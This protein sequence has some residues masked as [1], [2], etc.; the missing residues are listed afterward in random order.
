M[1]KSPEQPT[2][3]VVICAHNEQDWITHTLSSLLV[4]NRRPDE[5]V[6]VDNA[7]TDQTG[8]VVRQFIAE[9]PD[10]KILLVEE[11]KKGLHIAR[12][13]G[14]RAAHGDLIA[15]TD[16]DITFP[17]DWLQRIAAAFE[18]P[19]VG[20]VTGI[21]RYNDALPIAN[22]ATRWGDD[23]RRKLQTLCGGNNAV[24]RAILEAVDGYRDKPD[25]AFEDQYVSQKILDA[26]YS[27]KFDDDLLVWH[28]FR[29]FKGQGWRGYWR[30]MF[31]YTAE[32]IYSDHLAQ[33]SPYKITVLIP[34][35]NEEKLIE[36]CID[37]VARQDPLPYEIMVVDNASTDRTAEIV[38]RYI[39][40]HPKI[41]VKMIYET[42]KGCPAAREAGWRASGGDVIIHIDAD[43]IVPPG[44]LAR[45]HATLVR[46]PELGAIG[47][48]VRFEN[49]PFHIWL[50]QVLYNTLYP[51][52]IQ[53]SKGFPYLTGGMTICKREILERMNGFADRPDTEL[54][55]YYFSRKAHALGYKLRYIRS[56]YAIHSLRRYESGGLAGF[57]KWGEG[58]FDATKYDADTMNR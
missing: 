38:Q 19:A 53:W 22:W 25:G 10:Q 2:I 1:S 17:A 12:E 54:E 30:Y 9:H 37:S 48:A 14:W 46:D 3:S 35:F 8:V 45:V 20:A 44:W 13:T 56:I 34:A 47:G 31:G 7:S 36:R 50:I 57:L 55:D 16:A 58:G 42:K 18:D 32:N 6:V 21:T 33:D 43:E 41:N 23:N 11:P 40:S 52:I 49:A 28:S 51:R 5:I 29:R 4:Q 26:G 15:G 24:R 39:D 27:I